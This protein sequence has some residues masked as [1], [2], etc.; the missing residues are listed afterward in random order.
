[1]T[2]FRQKKKKKFTP[3]TR[4]KTVSPMIF[5]TNRKIFSFSA[6]SM[7]IL[8]GCALC[9]LA[10]YFVLF[11][12]IEFLLEFDETFFCTQN[13]R[14]C[15]CTAFIYTGVFFCV[16]VRRCCSALSISACQ[17]WIVKCERQ[18]E[19]KLIPCVPLD[20]IY[21]SILCDS[22]QMVFKWPIQVSAQS[23]CTRNAD[24]RS[25][26]WLIR[27]FQVNYVIDFEMCVTLDEAIPVRVYGFFVTMNAICGNIVAHA[28]IW[29]LQ[30]RN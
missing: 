6:F 14:E 28:D 16:T 13:T 23:I 11:T 10:Q 19:P 9:F 24:L 22:C 1:M 27:S 2:Q 26:H 20:A 5:G 8:I 7:A 29:K 4:A 21:R 18:R 3:R 15:I 30:I 17:C 12:R 25:T